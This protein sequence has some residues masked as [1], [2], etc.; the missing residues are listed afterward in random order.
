MPP[1]IDSDWF[2][3]ERAGVNY[4]VSAYD[5]KQWC[6]IIIHIS[7]NTNNV[8]SAALFGPDWSNSSRPKI[9][10]V[11]PGVTVGSTSSSNPA[12]VISPGVRGAFTL[13]NNGY[14]IGAGGAPS[15]GTGGT[16]LTVQ[17]L[18]KLNNLG[19]IAGGGGAGGQGG[20][21]GQGYYDTSGTSYYANTVCSG[22]SMPCYT[23]NP[24]FPCNCGDNCRNV[25]ACG[26]GSYVLWE[27]QCT[28]C[29]TTRT[30]TPGGAGGAGGRG[31]GSNQT[32]SDGLPGSGGGQSAGTG[33][34][35]GNGASLGQN[36]TA[37]TAGSN[38]N[39]SPGQPGQA[40]GLSGFY[41]V[42]QS[43]V[44]YDSVGIRLGRVS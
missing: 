44:S 27:K 39:Y 38:G 41:L 29:Y 21:G 23:L 30:I 33:G 2:L 8:N 4:K 15:G 31:E 5:V 12:M 7:S 1:I 43:F 34:Q 10:I 25:R 19:T 11:D 22:A 13:I 40:G 3:I 24:P 6:A 28:Y 42:G 14:I 32:R 36:G 17:S 20:T 16:G 35:G 26:D 18:T 9:L 37:G